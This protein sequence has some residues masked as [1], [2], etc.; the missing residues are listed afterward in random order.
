MIALQ[1]DHAA[2]EGVDEDEQRELRSVGAQTK[3]RRRLCQRAR[4]RG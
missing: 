3:L 1:S 4:R 2:D